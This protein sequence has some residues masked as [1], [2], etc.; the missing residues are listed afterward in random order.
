MTPCKTAVIIAAGGSGERFNSLNKDKLLHPIGGIVPLQQ[1]LKVF[2]DHAD[3]DSIVLVL[4]PSIKP[5]FDLSYFK[6]LI[7]VVSG[8]ENRQKS[9]LEGLSAFQHSRVSSPEKILVHDAARPFLSSALIDRIINALKEAD[10]VV[11]VI[12]LFDN[13][14]SINK[15]TLDSLPL[16]SSL[17]RTQ[18]PQGFLFDVLFQSALKA[19]QAQLSFRD[20]I[21]MVLNLCPH[22]HILQVEGDYENEK[23]THPSQLP[24]LNKLRASMPKTGIG[25]DIHY[26]EK[27]KPLVLGGFA[28]PD[29]DGLEGDSDGDVLTHAILD[30]LLGALSLGDMGSFFGLKTPELMGIQSTKL[31]DQ[32]LKYCADHEICF[33]I[34]H[35][36]LTLI[37]QKP[38]LS[39][40]ISSIRHSLMKSLP[41]NPS[42]ISIKSTTDKGMDAAGSGKGIRS[43]ALA[44]II[45]YS[46]GIT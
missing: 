2:N 43:I 37:A 40:F 17:Y 6:K 31:I 23:I 26:F 36:D 15:E 35:I 8:G 46:G 30:A 13:M 5:S 7:G 25:Y 14:I 16:P 32:L 45:L 39:P 28:I 9:V 27:G 38:L 34:C 4:N 3:I 29:S 42:S 33:D 41:L 10:G 18:T 20:E 11:P 12:P 44:T 21:T 24:F 1:S 19:E 22:A